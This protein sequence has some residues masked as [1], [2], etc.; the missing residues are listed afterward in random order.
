MSYILKVSQVT[1]GGNGQDNPV[2]LT[3]AN[4]QLTDAEKEFSYTEMNVIAPYETGGTKSVTAL[5]MLDPKT[6]Q[7]MLGPEDPSFQPCPPFC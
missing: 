7:P 6:G 4:Y 2:P 3:R 1:F 5:I